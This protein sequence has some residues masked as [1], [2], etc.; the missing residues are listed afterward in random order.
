MIVFIRSSDCGIFPLDYSYHQ[1]LIRPWVFLQR[2]P[3]II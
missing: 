3:G 2:L 1:L